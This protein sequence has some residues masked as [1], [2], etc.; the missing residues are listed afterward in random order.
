MWS[1]VLILLPGSA[2]ENNQ[3]LSDSQN[4]E[5]ATVMIKTRN[6][7][8]FIMELAVPGTLTTG[9]AKAAAIVPFP[10]FIAN[11][12]CKVIGAGAGA[13]PHDIDILKNGVSILPGYI[14]VSATFGTV[15][16][17]TPTTD[18]TQVLAGDILSLDSVATTTGPLGLVCEIT[19]SKD[20]DGI[21]TYDA[22]QNTV[23]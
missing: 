4:R 10:G 18:P 9:T 23:L 22:D 11:I 17:T 16:Y 2:L 19:L 3:Y 5:G 6:V 13:G 14:T 15:S 12:F 20:H 1:R 8:N 7:S 21:T